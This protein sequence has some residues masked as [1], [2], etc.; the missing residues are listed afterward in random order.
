MTS[1]LKRKPCHRRSVRYFAFGISDACHASTCD[2][3]IHGLKEDDKQQDEEK[4]DEEEPE[5]K[6][7]VT[8]ET[9]GMVLAAAGSTEARPRPTARPTKNEPQATHR[10]RVWFQAAAESTGAGKCW[11]ATGD[12]DLSKGGTL[13][14]KLW[15]GD[16]EDEQGPVQSIAS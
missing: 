6:S 11:H 14:E 12:V 8:S 3:Y 13:D 1:T 2:C 16:D 7:H 10:N 15:N 5:T 9:S 4:D